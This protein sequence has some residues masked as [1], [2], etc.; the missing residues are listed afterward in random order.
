MEQ[1]SHEDR[2]P[3]IPYE[4]RMLLGQLNGTIGQ[5]ILAVIMTPG[6]IDLIE[7]A[8]VNHGTPSH[9]TNEV[10]I[11]H[12][13]GGEVVRYD[14]N[15]EHYVYVAGYEE[16]GTYLTAQLTGWRVDDHD[17]AKLEQIIRMGNS[18]KQLGVVADRFNLDAELDYAWQAIKNLSASD[19]NTDYQKT[20]DM[21]CSVSDL[22]PEKLEEVMKSI[23]KNL[24]SLHELQTE[25]LL[26]AYLEVLADRHV[27]LSDQLKLICDTLEDP[28]TLEK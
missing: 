25:P 28:E 11:E 8:G 13:D 16:V 23:I 27:T 9:Q 22:D 18:A 12:I 20:I 19:C 10:C 6:E 2:Q 15:E 7:I 1:I 17:P 14:L 26:L 3:Y 24:N 21:L 4:R 5:P